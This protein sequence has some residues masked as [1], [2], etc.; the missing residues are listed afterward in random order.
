MNLLS[1]IILLNFVLYFLITTAWAQ[2]NENFMLICGQDKGQ[3]KVWFLDIKASVSTGQSNLIAELILR[4]KNNN[5]ITVP[6]LGVT[7]NNNNTFWVSFADKTIRKYNHYGL[8]QRSGKKYFSYKTA[9]RPDGLACKNP[10]SEKQMLHYSSSRT[11]LVHKFDKTESMSTKTFFSPTGLSWDN[12]HFKFWTCSS[13]A[14]KISYPVLDLNFEPTG[15]DISSESKTSRT[16]LYVCSNTGTVSRILV[17]Q[18][19]TSGYLY[20][21]WPSWGQFRSTIKDSYQTLLKKKPFVMSSDSLVNLSVFQAL[22]HTRIYNKTRGKHESAYSLKIGRAYISFDTREI[23]DTFLWSKLALGVQSK[24]RETAPGY[25]L[26]VYSLDFGRELDERDWSL[27]GKVVGSISDS[28]LKDHTTFAFDLDKTIINKEGRTQFK[29][30]IDQEE[31]S[32]MLPDPGWPDMDKTA[33]Q[34]VGLKKY[35]SSLYIC[36]S[37]FKAPLEQPQG[38]SIGFNPYFTRDIHFVPNKK[39]SISY[40]GIITPAKVILRITDSNSQLVKEISRTN[41]T[42]INKEDFWKEYKITWDRRTNKNKEAA[43]GIYFLNL[44]MEDSLGKVIYESKTS[45]NIYLNLNKPV[46][47][48]EAPKVVLGYTVKPKGK[49]TFNISKVYLNLY[50]Q[51]F[52]LIKRL[53]VARETRLN[54]QQTPEWDFSPY[55]PGLYHYAVWA[56]DD[57]GNQAQVKKGA[58]NVPEHKIKGSQPP[59]PRI[60]YGWEYEGPLIRITR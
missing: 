20:A 14:R 10:A 42:A 47:D 21:G 28:N 11:N 22:R 18:P 1:R 45:P 23:S 48:I 35:G 37:E 39:I 60:K 15:L 27:S 44:K 40:K 52:N 3:A 36:T 55:Q 31:G 13:V 25:N 58:F 16:V 29:I 5:A 26:R 7:T 49:I 50:D 4:D 54:Q 57:S 6:P 51:D 24:K 41:L 9:N 30:S 59:A 46:I 32:L 38:L 53:V 56:E 17:I 33:I 12:N 8:L 34:S 2:D 19:Q 43:P